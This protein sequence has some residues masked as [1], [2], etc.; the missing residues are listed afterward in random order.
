[1]KIIEGGKKPKANAEER[2]GRG[3]ITEKKK[4]NITISASR[5]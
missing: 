2:G 4:E 1:V 5:N 3:L